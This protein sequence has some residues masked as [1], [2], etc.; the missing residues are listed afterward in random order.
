MGKTKTTLCSAKRVRQSI[1]SY[2][3][4]RAKE[5]HNSHQIQ[6]QYA[7]EVSFQPFNCTSTYRSSKRQRGYKE[8]YNN[9]NYHELLFEYDHEKR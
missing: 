1:R 6:N 5:S 8:D 9:G 3:T 2:D 4:D 7:D